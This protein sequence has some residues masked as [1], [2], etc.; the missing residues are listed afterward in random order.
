MCKALQVSRSGYYAFISHSESDRSL[1]NKKLLETIKVIHKKSY[2]IYGA[3]QITKNLPEDQK[4]SKGRVAR[5]MK[6]DGIR[7]KVTKKYKVTTNSRHNLLDAIT[8][9]M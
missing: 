7:S 9:S 3:P 5:L 4:A 6:A 2:G 8:T 1:Q